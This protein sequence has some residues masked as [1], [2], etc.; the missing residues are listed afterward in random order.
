MVKLVVTVLVVPAFVAMG[1]VY[2][3]ELFVV[4]QMMPVRVVKNVVMGI[5]FQK[6]QNAAKMVQQVIAD[7]VNRLQQQ[8]QQQ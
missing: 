1:I 7:V 3:L 8:K 2:Q 6:I 5:V 4:I